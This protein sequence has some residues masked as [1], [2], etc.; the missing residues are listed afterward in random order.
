MVFRLSP[1][2]PLCIELSYCL[3]LLFLLVSLVPSL[4]GWLSVSTLHLLPHELA[5][6]EGGGQAGVQDSG[7]QG[8]MML[9]HHLRPGL[10]VLGVAVVTTLPHK[11]HQPESKN[12]KKDKIPLY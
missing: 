11:L 5:G 3:F 9:L 2:L 6:S 4:S 12:L 8:C 7:L 10:N 1:L